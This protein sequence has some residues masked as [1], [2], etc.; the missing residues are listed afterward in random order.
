MNETIGFRGT[1][2]LQA[3]VFLVTLVSGVFVLLLLIFFLS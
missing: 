2:V 1:R 3:Y